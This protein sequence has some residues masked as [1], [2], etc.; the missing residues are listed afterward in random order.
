MKE[1]QTRTANNTDGK[2]L[3]ELKRRLHHESEFLRLSP[4]EKDETP[5][6]ETKRINSCVTEKRLILVVYTQEQMIGYLQAQTNIDQ[7][8]ICNVTIG[9]LQKHT[10]LGI[11]STL[12][13]EME[14]WATHSKAIRIEINVMSHNILALRLYKRF[15]YQIISQTS[16]PL[17]ESDKIVQGYV[18]EKML[19]TEIT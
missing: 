13:N 1:W 15:G 6:D 10:G 17:Y 7:A 8:F 2:N 12:I 16:Y 3:W 18:L 11:G 5:I 14:D 4:K 19:L 9:I